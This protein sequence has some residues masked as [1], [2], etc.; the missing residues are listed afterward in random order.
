M[1]TFTGGALAISF[2][3]SI[4]NS[5]ASFIIPSQYGST[6]DY[7][8]LHPEVRQVDLIIESR[9]AKIVS[10][11]DVTLAFQLSGRID[12]FLVT[13]GNVVQKDAVLVTINK[14]DLELEADRAVSL[15]NQ[16]KI[17]LQKI[18]NG[19]RAE[20]L[21]ISTSKE[22]LSE[23]T[24]DV[25]KKTL[26]KNLEDLVT[27][28]DDT[29]YNKL[30]NVFAI[31]Q[32][33]QVTFKLVLND[34][35]LESTIKRDVDKINTLFAAYKKNTPNATDIEKKIT[36]TTAVVDAMSSLYDN[37]AQ[38]VNGARSEDV[39]I[40]SARLTV[41]EARSLLSQ[42]KLAF[43]SSYT[44]YK[45]AKDTLS[46]SQNEKKLL[47][48]GSSREDVAIAE[49]I[50]QERANQVQGIRNQLSFTSLIAPS[51]NMLVKDVF[52]KKNETVTAG[53]PVVLLAYVGMKV[54]IDVEEEDI[55]AITQG[56]QAKLYLRAY[57][58]IPISVQVDSIE[59]KEIIKNESTYFRLNLEL[60]DVPEDLALRTGMTGDLSLFTKKKRDA[61]VLKK[62]AL[63]VDGGYNFILVNEYGKV[64]KRVVEVRVIPNDTEYVEIEGDVQAATEILY[65]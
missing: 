21:A 19:T 16:A 29:F 9:N 51:P 39:L 5:F 59:P 15:L 41:A 17:N 63:F 44:N 28:A 23:T 7:Q 13:R 58:N 46:I 32:Q 40:Q 22:K 8:V 64:V 53:Q 3:P 34:A 54:Q 45:T 57:K 47:E 65:K 36:E 6:G 56:D 18:R 37:I 11:E 12:N 60:K 48:A 20:D 55:A 61:L 35:N 4:A 26:Q 42:A 1:I 25:Q 14:R 52:V 49:S 38:G 2:Y 50:V 62:S 30:S 10:Q 27:V 43:S 33:G 31:N 24:I